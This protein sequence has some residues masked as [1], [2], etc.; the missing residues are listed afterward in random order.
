MKAAQAVICLGSDHAG[1]ALKIEIQRFLA[2]LGYQTRDFGAFS[3]DK[4]SD[5]PEFIIPAVKAAVKA[6][7]RAIVF[8]GSGIGECIAANKVKGAR[9]ALAFDTYTAQITRKHNDSNVLCLGGR[10]VTGD[11]K[12]AKRLVRIWLETPFSDDARHVRR[13]KQISR[14]EKTGRLLSPRS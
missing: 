8:G 7:S 10:T 14:F 13:L 9:A 5:Y 3:A 4:P 11:V 12:L 2:K 6:K 1:Y